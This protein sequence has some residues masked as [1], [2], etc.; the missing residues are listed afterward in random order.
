M[1]VFDSDGNPIQQDRGGRLFVVDLASGTAR[2]LP[3]PATIFRNPALAPDGGSVVAEAYHLTILSHPQGEGFP[4]VVDTVVTG[5]PELW[6]FPL[7]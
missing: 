5:T 6:E 1:K 2:E 3:K 7:R 4:L